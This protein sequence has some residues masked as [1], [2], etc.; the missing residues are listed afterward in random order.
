MFVTGSSKKNLD[1]T[2]ARGL[3][4]MLIAKALPKHLSVQAAEWMALTEAC[5]IAKKKDK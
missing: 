5:K 3:T 1:G 2:N 4:E